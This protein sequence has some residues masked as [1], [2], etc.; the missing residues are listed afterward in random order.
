ML[1]PNTQSEGIWRW[2]LL[3]VIRSWGNGISIFIRE[4]QKAPST[5]PSC[6][7]TAKSHL[8]TRTS[9]DTKSA[10]ILDFPAFRTVRNK[11]LLFISHQGCDIVLQQPEWPRHLG[12]FFPF[13]VAQFPLLYIGSGTTCF[14][15]ECRFSN[16]KQPTAGRL[17]V[18][19]KSTFLS[20]TSV[21]FPLVF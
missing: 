19:A 9:P 6:E 7:V 21:S 1:N 14:W 16:H 10:S 2:D 4:T 11:F 13:S 5:F 17:A 20:P 3:G 12:K 18:S 8:W 15:S